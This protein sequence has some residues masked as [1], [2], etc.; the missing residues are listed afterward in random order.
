M[1]LKNERS[2]EPRGSFSISFPGEIKLGNRGAWGS[3]MS[4][5]AIGFRDSNANGATDSASTTFTSVEG[6]EVSVT[7]AADNVGAGT[8]CT[9][10]GQPMMVGGLADGEE[11]ITKITLKANNTCDVTI[12]NAY[13]PPE[14]GGDDFSVNPMGIAILFNYSDPVD[15]PV[16]DPPP[17]AN[18][19]K[20]TCPPGGPS[21]GSACG[22]TTVLSRW[23]G[24]Y[25]H[26]WDLSKIRSVI[27]MGSPPDSNYLRVEFNPNVC[28]MD[29]LAASACLCTSTTA[30]GN[31]ITAFKSISV[32]RSSEYV[33]DITVRGWV[34]T[35]VADSNK[36][37]K[38]SR[39]EYNECPAGTEL[40]NGVCEWK[41]VEKNIIPECVN[42]A[43]CPAS[44]C[45]GGRPE[46]NIDIGDGDGD[47]LGDCDKRPTPEPV[48]GSNNR[49]QTYLYDRLNH[50]FVFCCPIHA[51]VTWLLPFDTMPP[52]FQRYVTTT[53]SV[54]VAAQMVNNPQLFQLL[55][56]R[57]NTLR[58]ECMNYE[59]EQAD[60]NFLNQ[61]DHSTYMSYQTMQTL[62]R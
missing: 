7:I 47:G 5:N 30:S 57:E 31:P 60:L 48:P 61:P 14:E 28:D 53:A 27:V 16:A 17:G 46:G 52:V 37:S 55:K 23:H 59:M 10:N 18:G 33:L 2:P 42:F 62:N 54:R 8:T 56:D 40:I 9:I 58:M 13:E 1:R 35:G 19:N 12:I 25:T 41:T 20:G 6:R 45:E 11:E 51:D 15:P 29:A 49:N 38:Q 50:T 24:F 32:V 34:A 26:S 21:G 3:F 43:C 4:A 36:K 44:D 39:Q 22:T